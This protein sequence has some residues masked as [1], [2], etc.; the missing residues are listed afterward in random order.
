M[1]R[2]IIETERV[3]T[4]LILSGEGLR[5]MENYRFRNF[6]RNLGM[7]GIN[8][9]GYEIRD[10]N[11]KLRSDEELHDVTIEKVIFMRITREQ[12]ISKISAGKIW[13]A[14]IEP[15]SKHIRASYKF[16]HNESMQSWEIESLQLPEWQ[17]ELSKNEDELR[18]ARVREAYDSARLDRLEGIGVKSLDS[19]GV[20]LNEFEATYLPLN[21]H[22]S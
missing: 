13:N 22:N 20:V 19:I 12:E 8:V 7:M 10:S 9:A 2:P 16:I 5:T 15:R 4:S 11:E 3:P 6:V 21:S 18:Y 1:S 17:I 14:L